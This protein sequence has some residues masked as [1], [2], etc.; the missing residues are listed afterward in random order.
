[1]RDAIKDIVKHTASLFPWVLINGSATET[2]MSGM[3]ADKT[4]ILQAA[5]KTPAADLRGES[6]L[7]SLALLNGLLNFA[8]YN[9]DGSSFAAKRFKDD[10]RV[11]E[12]TFKDAKKSG[13]SYRL[14][15]PAMIKEEDRPPVVSDI[16]WE[17]SFEPQKDRLV[18]FGKL[19]GLL[20]EVDRLFM[21]KTIDGDL[22]FMFG[23][24]GSSTHRASMV[25]EDGV[26]GVIKGD[27]KYSVPDLQAT[28]KLAAGD[29]PKLHLTS[30]GVIMVSCETQFAT[31]QYIVRAT[32]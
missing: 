14:M 24:E 12:F 8:P 28:I 15:N 17:M 1:M 26:V 30:R 9:V 32:R 6:S 11:E 20:S 5:L 4:I 31:Y 25:F 10:S 13:A 29:S 16:P 3:T 19:A 22:H 27:I 23:D 2:T 18:E 21:P 7:S